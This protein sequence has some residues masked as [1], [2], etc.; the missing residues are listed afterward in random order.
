MDL[1]DWQLD[2]GAFR[3]LYLLGV[4][5]IVAGIIGQTEF[6]LIKKYLGAFKRWKLSV[7]VCVCVGVCARACMEIGYNARRLAL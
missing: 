5:P 2:F 1:D 7:C 6:C 4:H 3:F